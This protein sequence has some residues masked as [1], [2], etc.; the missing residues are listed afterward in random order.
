MACQM[1][2]AY[3]QLRRLRNPSARDDLTAEEI[4]RL[5]A[6][7]VC[8]HGLTKVRLTGGDPTARRDLLTIIKRLGVIAGLRDLAMTTNGLTLYKSIRKMSKNNP[9]RPEKIAQYQFKNPF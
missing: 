2:C 3:C 5:V 7:L 9:K 8:R 1:R 4:G 6:H